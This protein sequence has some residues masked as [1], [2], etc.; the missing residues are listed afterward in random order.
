MQGSDIYK[1][2]SALPEFQSQFPML[3]NYGT[4]VKRMTR[5]LIGRERQLRQLKAGLLRPELC[6][7]LLLGDAGAGKALANDT[8]IPVAD[9]RGY[10][11]ISDIAIGD[12][13]Y[14]ESGEPVKVTGVFPQGMKKAYRVTLTD[15]SSIVCNDEH[16]WAARTCRQHQ[17]GGDYQVLTL[18]EM[19]D[20][21]ILKE[22]NKNTKNWYIPV[23][24]AVQRDS[25]QFPIHPY[26]LGVLIGDGCLSESQTSKPLTI[27][28]SDVQ[29]VKR[30]AKLIGAV[31]IWRQT[32]KNYSWQFIRKKAKGRA[33]KFV[34]LDELMEICDFDCVFGKKSI[35]R[36]IPDIYFNGSIEQ[37]FELL[38]GLM[39]TDGCITRNSRVRCSFS[40]GSR[41]LADDIMTLAASL[42]IRTTFAEINRG[43]SHHRNTEYTVHFSL[44]DDDK[45]HL[46][47]L[48]RHKD[49][50][51][52]NRRYDRKHNKRYDDIAIASVEDLGYETEMTCIYVDT[53]SHLF[54]ATKNH[55]VTHNT[56][57]VQGAM[58]ADVSRAYLEID[59]SKMIADL[60]D[61]NEMAV[62]IKALF[63]ESARFV[64][65]SGTEI[66]LFIDEF[67]LIC[68]LSDAA[69]EALKPMLADSGTRG[70]RVIVATTFTEFRMY[71]SANQPLVQR[72]QRIEILPPSND[73]IV[74]ILKDFARIYGV[75]NEIHGNTL[76]EQIIELS[77]RYIPANSQPRKSILLLD[78]MVGWF[79]AEP[80]TK[81]NLELLYD[82]LKYS[83]GIEL[84]VHVDA[85]GIKKRLDSKV[86]AQYLATSAVASRLQITSADLNNKTKPMGSFLFTGST[87]VGKGLTDDTMVPVWTPDGSLYEKRNGDLQI[88][89]YV[90]NRKGKPVQ[91][92]GVFHRGIQDIY[93]V[94]LSDGRYLL[95]DSSHLWTYM[96]SKGKYSANTYTNSTKELF[97]RGVYIESKDGRHKLKYWIPMNHAV[98]YPEAD[99]SVHPYVMGAFIGDGSLTV[100]QL[101]L[102]SSDEDLVAHVA[103]L[104]GDCSY[105]HNRRNYNWIF[106]L[107]DPSGV[108]KSKQSTVVFA[109]YPEV[110]DKKANEK[111]IPKAYMYASEEQRWQLIKGLFDT[112]GTITHSDGGRYSL[113][114]SS[115]SLELIKDIQ[116]V[117]Y[118]LGVASSYNI[119]RKEKATGYTQYRLNV[120]SSNENKDRFFWLQRKV[121]IANKAKLKANDETK[122][123]KKDYNWVGIASIELLSEQNHTTCIMVD[124]EE[125]LYQAGMYVVSHNTELTKQLAEILFADPKRLIRFDM[126]EYS[127]PE[128]IE[129]FRVE[130][131]TKVWERPY[132]VLLFDEIEKACG[133]VTRI[134]L[135]VL[136]DGRLIDQNNREVSFLNTYIVLTTNAA[137]EIYETIGDYVNDKDASDE[138]QIRAL[139]KY[140]KVIR[141]AI[142]EGTGNNKFPPELL[143]RIDAICPFMPLS[144]DTQRKILEKRMEKLR[145]EVEQK[146]NLKLSYDTQNILKYILRDK[147]D[148]ESNSGG[149]RIVATKFEEEVVIEV[150][151]VINVIDSD[152]DK[153]LTHDNIKGIRVVVEGNMAVDDKRLLE[154]DAYIAAYPVN[155]DNKIIKTNKRGG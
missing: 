54:Q 33:V 149:A 86:F 66:V 53:P 134:L 108:V 24:G 87:G 18:R 10:I 126:T 151:R 97:E 95:T 89:D 70:V 150:A 37:R 124:D 39:D 6:N 93:K 3:H 42:G 46:F 27:S 81:M 73:A 41:D 62:K 67:H 122:S 80:G 82:V 7:V 111:R 112:D 36:R 154:G 110:C 38:H 84:N 32:K 128:S 31:D 132:S 129:R 30:V 119:S 65:E 139:G 72:L 17:I 113:S 56:A 120:K 140:M 51:D 135:Q 143:G 74:S 153:E 104:L 85:V 79:R 100:K 115:T 34:Q 52:E 5:K 83:E 26:A 35:D 2:I 94:T 22:T 152:T 92:T 138:D 44:S 155:I 136:D 148:T 57:L 45:K 123:H 12:K 20:A 114:Y 64:K 71:I 78:L 68:M 125:H 102:S 9:E 1:Q 106:P 16:L 103:E 19:M 137:S 98:Q 55:I 147:L 4:P 11:P 60:R 15:G 131:T 76:Y 133:D 59:I 121:D 43:D 130:V 117:L 141:R 40:T 48:E 29:V 23:N 145:I 127:Q 96:L 91:V 109:D 144:E 69:V 77:N 50:L 28:S 88:G 63:D 25:L 99:L 58:A 146:H 105:I 118:S 21:G 90:F 61:N 116:Q 49:S 47:W 13:V 107:N 75:D 14:N 8:L 142:V 101:T